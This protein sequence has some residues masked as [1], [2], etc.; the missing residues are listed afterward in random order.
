MRF[1]KEAPAIVYAAP[2]TKTIVLGAVLAFAA[3]CFYLL[4]VLVER[5]FAPVAEDV[6]GGH[7]LS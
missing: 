7:L 3:A 2:G 5:L 6:T 1:S 4:G